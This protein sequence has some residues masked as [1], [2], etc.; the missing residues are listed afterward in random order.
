MRIPVR[1]Q[2]PLEA[3]RREKPSWPDLHRDELAWRRRSRPEQQSLD[4]LDRAHPARYAS[5]ARGLGRV[6]LHAT[7]GAHRLLGTVG[8]P[9]CAI[10]SQVEDVGST[11][12][13][14]Y[15]DDALN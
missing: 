12:V 8:V 6:A 15:V 7:V 3:L 14:R 2:L 4:S 11:V 9:A 10:N 5:G 13:A 1:Q